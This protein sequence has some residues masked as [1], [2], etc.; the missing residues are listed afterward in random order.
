MNKNKN[1]R[2]TTRAATRN[3]PA[4]EPVKAKAGTKL[5]R[6]LTKLDVPIVED[7]AKDT[8]ESSGKSDEERVHK[9]EFVTDDRGD[10]VLMVAVLDPEDPKMLKEAL[11]RPEL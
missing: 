9:V 8:K 11:A 5:A 1:N 6:E 4:P 3:K 2:I 10:F 7:D